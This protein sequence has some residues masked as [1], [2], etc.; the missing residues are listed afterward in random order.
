VRLAQL[1]RVVEDTIHPGHAIAI[2]DAQGKTIVRHGRV[3]GPLWEV[4]LPVSDTG[5]MLVAQA[6]VQWLTLSGGR[7]VVAGC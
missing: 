6:P 5:W 4:L 1:Q 2:V 7:Q 3:E